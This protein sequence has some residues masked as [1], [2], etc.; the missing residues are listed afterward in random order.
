MPEASIIFITLLICFLDNS[1]VLK[2]VEKPNFLLKSNAFVCPI[3]YIYVKEMI[4]DL[5]SESSDSNK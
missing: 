5:F 3:P 4:I 2:L 1:V